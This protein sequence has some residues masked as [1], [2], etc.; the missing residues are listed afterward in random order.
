MKFGGHAY[1]IETFNHESGKIIG[2]GMHPEKLQQGLIDIKNYFR[3]VGKYRGTLSLI[4]GLP[5]ETFET[6][7]RSK[8]WLLDNWNGEHTTMLPLQIPKLSKTIKPSL[9]SENFENYG[10]SINT[11]DV[12][13]DTDNYYMKRLHLADIPGSNGLIN[14]KNSNMNFSDA[15][16]YA[17]DLHEEFMSDNTKF[18]TTMW[19]LGDYEWTGLDLNAALKVPLSD[20]KN[21]SVIGTAWDNKDLMIA[22]Y[23][24]KKLSQ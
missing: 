7:D 3:S 24:N 8:Q 4:A 18:T 20:E 9:I 1:G 15:V 14:W 2:K 6:L 19:S 21:S 17:Y 23:I 12:N 13:F 10:Y 16:R 5:H 11:S 22:Q